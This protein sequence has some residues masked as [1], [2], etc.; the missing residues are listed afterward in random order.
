MLKVLLAVSHGLEVTYSNFG[1]GGTASAFQLHEIAHTHYWSKEI[2]DI[3]AFDSNQ[4]TL[5]QTSSPYGSK[6]NLRSPQSPRGS[7]E[8]DASRKS[9]QA[10]P[11][12]VKLT[13][14]TDADSSDSQSTAEMFKDLLNQKR[15]MLLSKLTSFDSDVSK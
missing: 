4:L 5:S 8:W 12:S 9:S 15:N 10:D 2:S 11:P 3:A 1:L 7:V 14:D 6:E 13:Q